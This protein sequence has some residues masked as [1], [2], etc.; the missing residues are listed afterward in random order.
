MRPSPAPDVFYQANP[1]ADWA[2]LSWKRIG[3]PYRVERWS[4]AAG[5]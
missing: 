5:S 4:A 1:V 2:A 3:R